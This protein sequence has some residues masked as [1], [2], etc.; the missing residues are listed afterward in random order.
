MAKR[1]QE[2]KQ[3]NMRGVSGSMFTWDSADTKC[4]SMP[5]GMGSF[6][7]DGLQLTWRTGELP[8]PSGHLISC[9]CVKF[10][11]LVWQKCSAGDRWGPAPGPRT[12]SC[13]VSRRSSSNGSTSASSWTLPPF[14]VFRADML[15]SALQILL[16]GHHWAGDPVL[17]LLCSSS[18]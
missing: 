13:F 18:H 11:I 6:S 1:Q 8:I 4:W 2:N 7:H 16:L 15:K 5:W 9:T 10:Q 12:I 3:M 14:A 17:K